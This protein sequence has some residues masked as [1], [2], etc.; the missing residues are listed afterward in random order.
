MNCPTDGTTLLMSERQGIE[1]DYCPQCRGI[2]LDRGELDKLLERA[3]AEAATFA[4]P[5]QPPAAAG[6]A[7]TYGAP[8]P[9]RPVAEP[10]FEERRDTGYGADP[11]DRDRGFDRGYD[12]DRRYRERSREDSRSDGY[13]SDG[14]RSDDPR[15]RGRRKKSPFD[16]LGDIFD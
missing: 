16:F 7:A 6:P 13:R 2:W 9:A 14:Y 3:Q 12:D 10:R 15:Y 1:I 8:E 4:E 11:R 5:Q